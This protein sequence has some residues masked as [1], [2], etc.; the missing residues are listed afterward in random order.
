MHCLFCIESSNQKLLE[1]QGVSFFFFVYKHIFNVFILPKTPRKHLKHPD[2]HIH[3]IKKNLKT[4][5]KKSKINS[6]TKTFP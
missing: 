1:K 3:N 5:L 6:N 4:Q 2:K